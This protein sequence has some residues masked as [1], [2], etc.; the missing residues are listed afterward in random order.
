MRAVT[1]CIGLAAVLAACKSEGGGHTQEVEPL[2]CQTVPTP[3]GL[4]PTADV[5][6]AL[7][8]AR[9]LQYHP[10]R[11]P[12]GERRRLTVVTD[13]GP[14][15]VRRFR[16]GAEVEIQPEFCSHVNDSQ[17]LQ[18]TS[19]RIVARIITDSTYSKLG[20]PRDTSYLWIQNL[21]IEGDSGTAE[22]LIIPGNGGPVESRSVRVDY[23][24][25]VPNRASPEARLLFTEQ[26]DELWVSCVRFG[27]CYLEEGRPTNP[28]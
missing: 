20:L 25:Q 1:C 4:N 7:A 14:V 28:G 10:G 21:V 16:L 3:A 5:A 6:G 27:C 26:D 23:H 17:T 22:G 12:H 2:A 18:G 11:S 24:P 13:T 8:H 9:Q 15:S 19:G